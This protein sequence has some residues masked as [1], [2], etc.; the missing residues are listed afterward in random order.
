MVIDYYSNLFLSTTSQEDCYS[1]VPFADMMNHSCHGNQLRDH[2]RFHVATTS[3]HAVICC[4]ILA[5]ISDFNID[6]HLRAA[7]SRSAGCGAARNEEYCFVARRGIAVGEELLL[8]YGSFDNW[9]LLMDY[10]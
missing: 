2:N 6:G 8:C 5:I 4:L 1:L 9:T 3:N 7:V 10:G